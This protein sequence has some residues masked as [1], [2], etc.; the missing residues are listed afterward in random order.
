MHGAWCWAK[1]TDILEG[2]GHHCLDLDLPGAGLDRTPRKDITFDDYIERI[3]HFIE[4]NDFKDINLVGHSLAGMLLPKI[5]LDEWAGVTNVIFLSAYI[6][7]RGE[8]LMDL[9]PEERAKIV[10]ESVEKSDDNTYL[11]GYEHAI[12]SYLS[13]LDEDSR[14]NYYNLFTP[15]PLAPCLHKS[16]VDLS[17]VE[18]TMHYIRCTRDVAV[19]KEL[20]E[21]FIN[22]IKCEVHDID[23][24]HDVML[25]HPKELAGLLE[26]IA[27]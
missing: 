21:S 11:P 2:D 5:A 7:K 17:L 20:A 23:A 3:D 4:M 24:H 10:Y 14:R 27:K 26:K 8:S 9:M 25:S 1:V 18:Q 16:D 6:L 13:D 19:N 15:Q 22:K 12:K